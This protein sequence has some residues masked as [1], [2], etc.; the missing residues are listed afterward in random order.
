MGVIERLADPHVLSG[1][2]VIV[3]ILFGLYFIIRAKENDLECWHFIATKG[4]DGKNYADTDKLG[5]LVGI[6]AGTYVVIFNKP[7]SAM[8][9]IYLSYVGAVAG[10]SSYLRSKRDEPSKNA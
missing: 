4:L 1:L 3:G 9:F 5:K 6:I 10:W 8:L 2:C 7:D